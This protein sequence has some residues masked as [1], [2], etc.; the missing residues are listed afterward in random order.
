[1]KVLRFEVEGGDVVKAVMS[2]ETEESLGEI[3][4][5]SKEESS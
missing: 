2:E 3:N 1:M 5:V 4:H